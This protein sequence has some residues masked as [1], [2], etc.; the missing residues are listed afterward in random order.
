MTTDSSPLGAMRIASVIT[1]INV[2]VAGG[3]SMAG[4]I[5][6]CSILPADYVPTQAS[7]IFAMYAAARTIPLAVITLAAIFRHS[8]STLL[9]LG[10]LAGVTQLLDSII[11]VV[12][13]DLGKNLR[14]TGHCRPQGYAVAILRRAARSG[15]MP[16][17]EPR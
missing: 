9:I 4:L 1:A 15:F 16:P 10:T 6:P 17:V 8:V 7:S 11:G 2:L 12:Q 3:F 5:Y 14:T 13:H